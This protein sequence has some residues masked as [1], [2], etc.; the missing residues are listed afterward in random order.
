ME[1]P[2][3]ASPRVVIIGG[4]FGGIHLARKL[5]NK[6]FQVVLVDK[7][8]FHT[9]QP[10]LYQVATAALD[11]ASISFPI[12]KIFHGYDDYY[13][14]MADVREIKA[15]EKMVYTDIGEIQ[16]DYLVIATG[17]QTN[18]FG[19]E[20]LIISSMPMK[21]VA[22]AIDLRSLIL[23]NFEKA[24]SIQ[25]ERKKDSLMTFA[26]AGA[27]PTGVELAGAIGELKKN[28]LPRDYPELDFSRMRILLIQSGN[29]VLPALSE[30][31]SVR[32]KRFL[33]KLGVEV[34]LNTRVL[35]YFGDYIQTNQK[36][37]T[38]RTLIWTTGV[39]GCPVDGLPAD[40]IEKRNR[41]ILVDV[42]NRVEGSEHVFAI[43]DCAAM[44]SDAFPNG[45]PQVAP[46]AIQQGVLLAE[47]LE[48]LLKNKPLKP[49]RYRDKGSMA[50]IGKNK[51]VV[52]VGRLKTGGFLAWFVWMFIHLMSLVGFRNKLIV[53][54]DWTRS[55]FNNDKGVRVIFQQFDLMEEKKRRKKEMLKEE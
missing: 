20:G 17:S 37:Y 44:I 14:R 30:K 40:S 8:N 9:F 48:R 26:I 2:I 42:Y 33:E 7:Q 27:G 10:L 52:E 49:F 6:G 55:Y 21:S 54:L 34:V 41:R 47:N 31:S 51:A 53:F 36:D 46:A 38:A 22:E 35:D 24:L 25:N 15:D 28:I 12:R 23:Q 16:Y 11:P 18:Y 39:K 45:H 3:T 19:M 1:I 13:F 50:T 32:A 4:G 43:G 5:R 29:R